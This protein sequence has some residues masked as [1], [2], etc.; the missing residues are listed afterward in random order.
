MYYGTKD[1]G[2]LKA[3]KVI[4]RLPVLLT[5]RTILVLTLQVHLDPAIDA[6]GPFVRLF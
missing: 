2:V 3:G 6:L 5:P 4:C 1:P